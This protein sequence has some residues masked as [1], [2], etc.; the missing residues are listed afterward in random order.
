[1]GPS[2]ADREVKVSRR[3]SPRIIIVLLFLSSGSLFTF[4]IGP[5]R[6]LPQCH[7]P[8]TLLSTCLHNL[9]YSFMMISFDYIVALDEFVNLLAFQTLH[10]DLL[11]DHIFCGFILIHT[12][13]KRVIAIEFMWCKVLRKLE[14]M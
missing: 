3:V 1:M 7:F 13:E 6:A 14:Y 10:F 11:I 9:F 5:N 12:I 4:P 8:K 2:Y